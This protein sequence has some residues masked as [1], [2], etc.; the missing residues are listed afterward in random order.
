[1]KVNHKKIT[2][3]TAAVLLLLL[4]GLIFLFSG[5][6]GEASGGL[7]LFIS[8]KCAELV[9]VIGNKHWTEYMLQSMA[10]YFEHPIR[11][12]AHFSEYACMGVLVYSMW[13]PW[14]SENR[15][16]YLLTTF[17]VF[18][19]ATVDELHQFFV[20]GRYC[21]FADVLLD[22]CGGIF[23]ILICIWFCKIVT[24]VKKKKS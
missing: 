7:S 24:A 2:T 6:D 14:L 10:E 13:R 12:L 18:V 23:G 17:W 15:R 1:M 20:P 3:V 9:N 8:E 19:S 11:K 21:S 4:Y 16:L 5:Q 22:T